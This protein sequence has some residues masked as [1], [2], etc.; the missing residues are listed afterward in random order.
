MIAQADYP[1]EFNFAD[2][3]YPLR[4]I[5]GVT[6]TV[7]PASEAVLLRLVWS[8]NCDIF[9]HRASKPDLNGNIT[10]SHKQYM[11]YGITFLTVG[12]IWSMTS[13]ILYMNV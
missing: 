9:E 4:R 6:Y 11:I 13:G 7:N 12:S 10:V 8:A 1:I 5:C 3:N 2:R